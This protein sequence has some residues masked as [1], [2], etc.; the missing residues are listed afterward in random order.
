MEGWRKYKLGEIITLKYGKDHKKLSDGFYP[1]YG[2]GG[3]MR[4]GN[5]YI[6]DQPSILIPRKGSLNNMMFID[7]PFWTVDTMFWSIINDKMVLPRFLYY[8]LSKYDFASLN[9]GS[10][11][12]SLT[13]PVIENI[14]IIIPSIS[15]QKQILS[16]LV[17][18]DDKIALNTRINDNLEQQAENLYN[19]LFANES[20]SGL[21]NLGDVVETTSG[22]TPSRSNPYFYKKGT[23]NWVKSKEL[24]GT[25]IINTEEFITD[26]A[27][28]K[29]AAKMLPENSVLIAMYGATVGEYAIIFKQMA[30]NQ[31]ICA[32]LPSNNYPYTYLFMFAKRKKE[33]LIN[34]AIGSAQQNISQI[35]VKQLSISKNIELIKK[36]DLIVYPFFEKIKKNVIEKESLSQ[37]RDSL[38][39][40]LMSGE[41]KINDLNNYTYGRK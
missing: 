14:E 41:L 6:Y 15:E 32:L 11:V 34:K 35:L 26:M 3:I 16:T 13:V 1:V 7:K 28:R 2:S 37:L 29:S 5:S 23:L 25:F 38:L 40:K 36:Y 9:V 18:L 21:I 22:G 10:A 27:V 24:N 4:Y 17:P 31:A 19:E 33:E 12:P 20:V 8:A 30:C 39:S